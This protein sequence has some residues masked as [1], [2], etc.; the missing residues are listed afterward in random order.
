MATRGAQCIRRYAGEIDSR[1]RIH[2]R[3]HDIAL[4]DKPR[5]RTNIR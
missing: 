5:N 4:G 3:E 2:D 1:A